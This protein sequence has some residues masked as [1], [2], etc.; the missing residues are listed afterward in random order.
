MTEIEILEDVRIFFGSRKCGTRLPAEQAR[1]PC[2]FRAMMPAASHSS[3][4]IHRVGKNERRQIDKVCNALGQTL[5]VRLGH[6][7]PPEERGNMAAI[8]LLG[9][10]NEITTHNALMQ[11]IADTIRRLRLGQNFTAA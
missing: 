4:R 8:D 10:F 11:L 1:E 5:S 7:L 2:A 3:V 9:A 6:D